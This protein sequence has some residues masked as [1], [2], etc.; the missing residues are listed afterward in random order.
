MAALMQL[1]L[2]TS[3]MVGDKCDV[4]NKLLKECVS[5]LRLFSLSG[6]KKSLF[7]TI[8]VAAV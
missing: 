6:T 1:S 4:V 2:F 7:F 3:F 8:H 5:R